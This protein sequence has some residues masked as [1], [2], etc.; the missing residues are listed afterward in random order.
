MKKIVIIGL[1]HGG[2]SAAIK[3]A[4]DYDITI[5]EKNAKEDIAYP[6]EDDIRL[7]I[8]GRLGLP[9]P[10]AALYNQKTQR[11]FVAP[12]MTDY[13]PLPKG[14]PMEDISIDRKGLLQHLIALAEAAGAKVV[15]ETPVEELIVDG[16]TVTGVRVGGENVKADLVVDASGYHSPFR[17]QVPK[18]FGMQAEP[19]PDDTMC[20]YR[21]YYEKTPG[22]ETPHP[23]R[24]YCLLHQGGAGLSW[25]NVNNHDQVDILIG[26]IGKLTEEQVRAA[27]ADLKLHND[28]F[29]DQVILPGRIVDISLRNTISIMVADGFALVGDSAFMTM[30]FMG[31]GIEA[32]LL[33][34]TLLADCVKDAA[35]FTAKDLWPY[36]VAYYKEQGASYAF[37]DILKRW[38]LFLDSEWMNWL[39][40]CG[41][42]K[43]ED[44]LMVSTSKDSKFSLTPKDI[45]ERLA[46]LTKRP[47]IIGS[48]VKCALHGVLMLLV[49]KNIPANYNEKTLALWR[50]CYDGLVP[51]KTEFPI[52]PSSSL[53]L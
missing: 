18:K 21:A 17:G 36:Q 8:F 30:P 37:I 2:L 29:S 48:A 27:E 6:W 45:L 4:K 7:D 49:A 44:M 26:R 32:S 40:G 20:V 19:A 43:P 14:K 51:H 22:T 24:H 41:A 53:Q 5:Y 13:L 47:E 38:V 25:C 50:K 3:L 11:C 34:G 39:L 23:E 16:N 52:R 15:Y 42:V 9:E 31:S 33:A 46:I 12:N 10:D 1:G 28:T 35:G